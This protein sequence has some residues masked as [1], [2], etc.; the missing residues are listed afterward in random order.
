[1]KKQIKNVIKGILIMNII[2]IL[3]G[4]IN[5]ESGETYSEFSVANGQA[6]CQYN[7]EGDVSYWVWWDGAL[8]KEEV[9]FPFSLNPAKVS[10]YKLG[11]WP[12]N[13]CC[14]DGIQCAVDSDEEESVCEGFA[15]NFCSDYNSENYAN[16]KD[17]C[18]AFNINTAIR[19]VEDTTGKPGICS[20]ADAIEVS[21]QDKGICNQYT[22]NCRCYWDETEDECKSTSTIYTFCGETRYQGNCTQNTVNK[23]DTCNENGTITYSWEAVWN[24][25]NTL[26]PKPSWCEG[27][28]KTFRCNI[29]RLS[30]FNFINVILVILITMIIYYF[31]ARK[32]TYGGLQ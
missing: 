12:S 30:G 9:G 20:G 25:D 13:G 4:I 17:Y 19:S 8:N 1:M 10:C 14:P 7:V 15:P 22:S 3:T 2:I 23:I 26:I 28:V 16:P 6:S 31:I 18:Q 5:A 24:S 27:G 11:G 29:V 21:I 32:E